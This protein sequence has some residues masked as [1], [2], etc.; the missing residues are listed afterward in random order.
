MSNVKLLPYEIIEA[1]RPRF[2]RYVK[3]IRK[4]SL[5]DKTAENGEVKIYSP[6]EIEQYKKDHGY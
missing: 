4:I 5:F 3:P 2:K 6:E 1:L